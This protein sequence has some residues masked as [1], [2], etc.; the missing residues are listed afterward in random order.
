MD[1]YPNSKGQGLS[2]CVPDVQAAL[3]EENLRM[4]KHIRFHKLL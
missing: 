3:T 4:D 1:A 2:L